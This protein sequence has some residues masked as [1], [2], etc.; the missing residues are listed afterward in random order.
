[1]S[2]LDEHLIIRK[3]KL[4]EADIA[5]L[6]TFSRLT[7]AQYLDSYEAQLQVERLLE[8]ITGRLID[9]NYHVLKEKYALIPN[10]YFDSFIRMGEKGETDK[11][12]AQELA[13]AAGLRNILAH[14]YDTIDHKQVYRAISQALSQIPHYLTAIMSGMTL[15]K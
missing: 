9:I 12:S 11:H 7:E 3:V 1:M 8:R 14:E 13:R 15:Q 5:I 6:K 4:I 10:D 2:P